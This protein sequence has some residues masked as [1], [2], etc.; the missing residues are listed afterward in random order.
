VLHQA[1]LRPGA[2]HVA[3]DGNNGVHEQAVKVTIA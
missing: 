1:G 2:S 3:F